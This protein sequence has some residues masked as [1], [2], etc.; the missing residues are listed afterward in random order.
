MKS[1]GM[2]KL[3]KSR[4][5]R[6]FV[7]LILSLLT[8]SHVVPAAAA[9]TSAPAQAPAS[10]PAYIRVGRTFN[11]RCIVP[12]PVQRVDVV[13]FKDYVKSVLPH[14]WYASWT[15]ASLDAGAVAVAQFGYVTAF[16]QRKWSS[17]GYHFDVVDST[18]DQVY[19]PARQAR[20]DAAVDRTW[21]M[22]IVRNGKLVSTYYRANWDMCYRIRWNCMSQWGSQTLGRQG[23]T[24]TQ[25]L[26][27]YYR[28]GAVVVR[29][30]QV[31]W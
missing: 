19:K 16:V 21:G 14:E 31:V 23:W 8:I 20:T 18:C 13:P 28:D 2:S 15:N 30:G 27:H 24:T 11:T 9:P 12:P 17:R 26:R 3:L 6:W 22:Q 10:Y 1:L 4:S 7:V 25:I 5:S 29:N